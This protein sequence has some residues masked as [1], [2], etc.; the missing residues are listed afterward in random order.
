VKLAE[1]SNNSFERN[2]VIFHFYRA[3]KTYSDP[4]YIF[5]EVRIY[6]TA[7]KYGMRIRAES[8]L[9]SAV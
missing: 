8:G 1:L 7:D 6:A 9:E 4:S 2:N 3:F 5:Q